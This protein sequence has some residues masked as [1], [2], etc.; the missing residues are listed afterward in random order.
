M[1]AKPSELKAFLATLQAELTRLQAQRASIDLDTLQS[2]HD[3]AKAALAGYESVHVWHNQDLKAQDLS[4]AAGTAAN[5]LSNAQSQARAL[6]QAMQPLHAMVNTPAHVVQA[7]AECL[8]QAE[9]AAAA[10]EAV[11]A[12]QTTVNN[13]LGLLA[14]ASATYDLERDSAARGVLAAAKAGRQGT[15]AL[16]DRGEVESLELA[17]SMAQTELA[18]AQSVHTAALQAQAEAIQALKGAEVAAARLIYALAKR[19]FALDVVQF[20]QAVGR[21]YKPGEDLMQLVHGLER[22]AD[23]AQ[24]DGQSEG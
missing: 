19:D 4:K 9:H 17:L 8:A 12:A 18:E 15:A 7:Q 20:R 11:T 13:V 22:R 23:D 10:S 21:S 3:T 1:A 16:A 5:A 14:D 24:T 6:D 2:Q